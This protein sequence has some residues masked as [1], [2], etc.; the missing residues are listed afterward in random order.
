L[1]GDYVPGSDYYHFT[2]D[3]IYWDWLFDSGMKCSVFRYH[4]IESGIHVVPRKRESGWDLDLSFE[5]GLL[6]V[7]SSQGRNSWFK[8][9]MPAE[10]PA[11][12][13]RYVFAGKV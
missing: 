10:C 11:N 6:R 7:T 1:Q 4:P 8:R 13:S 3:E 12:A 2:E 9:L 5:D